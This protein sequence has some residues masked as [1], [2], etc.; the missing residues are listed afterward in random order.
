MN[1]SRFTLIELLVV[2]GV[3]AILA[4]LLIPT[5]IGAQQKGRISQARAD[6]SSLKTAFSGLEK[7]YGRMVGGNHSLGGTAFTEDPSGSGCITI[8][9]STV[10]ADYCN[11]IAE[12]SDPGN[13][14]FNSVRSTSSF[15]NK[16]NIK[17]LDP[18]PEYNPDQIPSSPNNLN[19]TWLDPWGNP[20]QIRINFDGSGKIPDPSRSGTL[21][22]S[23]ILW[24]F[25]P[26]GVGN[27]TDDD[28]DNIPSWKEGNWLD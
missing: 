21:S 8:A 6:M 1:K 17:Y 15:L 7:D 5:V 25:G 19:N 18:R 12:L 22:G 20:Y 4:G 26:D 11:V 10:N 23:I 9:V 2:I 24:S 13:A 16:R 3:L 14:A 28:K 27:S